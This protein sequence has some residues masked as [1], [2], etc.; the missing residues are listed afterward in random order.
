MIEVYEQEEMSLTDLN[1]LS[2][3]QLE[4]IAET[5]CINALENARL[6]PI[7]ST[8][9]AD[10]MLLFQEPTFLQRFKLGL[11]QGMAHLLSAH[12][13]RVLAA[14]LFD[15]TTGPFIQTTAYSTSAITPH[16]LFLVSKRSAALYLLAESLDRALLREVKNLPVSPLTQGESL[17]NPLFITQTDVAKHKGYAMLLSSTP[18]PP[19]S[20]WKREK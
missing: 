9:Q 5:I 20:I 16:L 3:L 13:D 15:E 19:R 1:M 11:A 7:S 2:I 18:T 4:E 17:L 14:Y 10:L 8:Q 6:A 12:D